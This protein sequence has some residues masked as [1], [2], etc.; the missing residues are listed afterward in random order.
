LGYAGVLS[1]FSGLEAGVLS[2]FS[3]LGA[4][5]ELAL[6]PLPLLGVVLLSVT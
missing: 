3:G 1:A 4:G 6:E 5:D 2:A